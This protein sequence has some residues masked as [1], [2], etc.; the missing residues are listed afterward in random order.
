MPSALLAKIWRMAGYSTMTMLGIF[1]LGMMVPLQ[2][3]LAAALCFSIALRNDR[4]IQT[5]GLLLANWVVNTFI[6]ERTGT[7]FNWEIM[8]FVD[9][10]TAVLVIKTAPNRCQL[11]IAIIYAYQ[12]FCHALRGVIGPG[13]L[14]DYI[15]WYALHYGAWAQFWTV[16]IWGGH[17]GYKRY[18]G[19]RN[20]WR[21]VH[22]NQGK[23]DSLGANPREGH[24]Q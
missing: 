13:A 14:S 11:V 8:S 12:L 19:D 1:D 20:L 10:T 5:S 18:S 24:D 2:L 6:A 17:D 4:A 9:L 15:Y 3:C 21:R 23:L 16:L 22:L 7:Q